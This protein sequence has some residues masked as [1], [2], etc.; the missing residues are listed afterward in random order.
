MSVVS[1]RVSC[2]V[3][4]RQLV[5]DALDAHV[6]HLGPLTEWLRRRGGDLRLLADGVEVALPDRVPH[7]AQPRRFRRPTQGTPS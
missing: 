3:G 5:L 6:W 1:I 7:P 4:D 2:P